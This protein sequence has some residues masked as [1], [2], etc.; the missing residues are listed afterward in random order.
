MLTQQYIS[1]INTLTQSTRDGIL[2]WSRGESYKSYFSNPTPEQKVVIDKYY[3]IAEGQTLTCVNLTILGSND[4]LI[5]ETVLCGAI[6]DPENY[7]LLDSLYREVEIQFGN[8]AGKNIPPVLTH[9]TES[10]QQKMQ[11]HTHL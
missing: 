7:N 1:L 3:T 8:E 4:E 11:L 6:A 9:I 5:D 10:L 2:N